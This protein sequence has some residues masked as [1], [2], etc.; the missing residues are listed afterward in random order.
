MHKLPLLVVICLSSYFAA[1]QAVKPPVK[2]ARQARIPASAKFEDGPPF[3]TPCPCRFDEVG[4]V[5]RQEVCDQFI[6]AKNWTSAIAECNW[7]WGEIFNNSNAD[8][9]D[10]TVKLV[11]VHLVNASQFILPSATDTSVYGTANGNV[12][13]HVLQLYRRTHRS[14]TLI[15]RPFRPTVPY[16]GFSPP[17]KPALK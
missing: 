2:R 9:P 7:L 10:S 5:I 16:T 8:Y 17:L 15:V 12:R 4:P 6:L 11:R 1:A 13:P 14:D 3:K